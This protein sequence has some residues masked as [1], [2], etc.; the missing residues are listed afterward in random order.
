MTIYPEDFLTK[1]YLDE[2]PNGYILI[3]GFNGIQQLYWIFGR[4]EVHGAVVRS[5]DYA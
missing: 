4:K 5:R 2:C 3:G 1:H